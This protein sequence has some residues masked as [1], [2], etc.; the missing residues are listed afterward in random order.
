MRLG[1]VYGSH[2]KTLASLEAEFS[3][4]SEAG[5]CSVSRI[6]LGMVSA[7]GSGWMFGCILGSEK[8]PVGFISC[9]S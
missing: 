8:I 9:S 6:V 5:S 4:S 7:V 3:V 2:N 1:R